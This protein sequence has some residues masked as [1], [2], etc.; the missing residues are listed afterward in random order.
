MTTTQPLDLAPIQARHEA[1]TSGHWYLQPNYGPDFVA[2]ELA[3]Y[4]H[5]I[6]TL[7]FGDGD[8]A[9]ADREFVLNAHCDVGAL[10][11]R[12]VELEQQLA[13]ARAAAFREAARLLEEAGR[14]DD[15]VNLLDNVADGIACNSGARTGCP[16]PI[17]CDHE[18]EAGQLRAE[19]AAARRGRETATGQLLHFAAEAHRRKWAYDNGAEGPTPAAFAALHQLGNEMRATVDALTATVPAA[20]C[21]CKTPTHPGHYPSCPDRDATSAPTT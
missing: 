5:G 12:V 10:L 20:S 14:D 19:L 18:A 3:G 11:A 21:G 13:T 15:A 9:D 8:Q 6:G 1:A 17:E 2:S 7:N 4:E 16:D